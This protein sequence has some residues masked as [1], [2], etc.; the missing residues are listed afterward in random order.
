MRWSVVLEI[1][2]ID[3]VAF[4]WS[5]KLIRSIF[6]ERSNARYSA[7]TTASD[8]LG[9][10]LEHRVDV[11]R[12][13][14]HR[15]VLEVA[16]GVGEEADSVQPADHE[17]GVRDDRALAAVGGRVVGQPDRTA[18]LAGHV[19]GV[20]E[21]GA[22]GVARADDGLGRLLRLHVT[23]AGG[24]AEAAGAAASASIRHRPL[25]LASQ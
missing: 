24:L 21:V 6:F 23:G 2:S 20:D 12:A 15:G 25:P 5:T 7:S 8:R 19:G 22:V 10:R 11:A 3:W 16:A 18:A 4:G 1:V 13:E 14:R 17:A 9:H